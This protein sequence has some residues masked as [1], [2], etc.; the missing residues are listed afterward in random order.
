MKDQ[1]LYNLTIQAGKRKKYKKKKKS[2]SKSHLYGLYVVY[3]VHILFQAAW[4]TEGD[5]SYFSVSSF[6][7]G[8]K[9]AV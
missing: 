6:P 8:K 5:S 4:G 1:F 2:G 7:Q 9:L 3:F